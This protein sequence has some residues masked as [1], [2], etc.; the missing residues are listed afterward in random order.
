MKHRYKVIY[1][2]LYVYYVV[3]RKKTTFNKKWNYNKK[4]QLYISM[5]VEYNVRSRDPRFGLVLPNRVTRATS[6]CKAASLFV[7]LRDCTIIVLIKKSA[8]LNFPLTTGF[9]INRN[10]LGRQRGN[11]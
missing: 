5:Q 9:D 2:Y 7:K 6:Q 8:G 11:E 10:I 1:V 3:N 4:W